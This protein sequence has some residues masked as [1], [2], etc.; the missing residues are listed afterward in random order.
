MLQQRGRSE[1]GDRPVRVDGSSDAEP[2]VTALYFVCAD[3]DAIHGEL[4]ARGL[5]LPPPGLAEYGMKQLR[6]PEPDGHEIWFESF[7][8]SPR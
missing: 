7:H 1:S 8:P 3:V 6:V 4:T 5:E 2:E